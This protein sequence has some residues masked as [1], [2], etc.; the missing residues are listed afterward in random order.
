[1][2]QIE[3]SPEAQKVTPE[4]LERRKFIMNNPFIP[5]KAYFNTEVTKDNIRHFID[6]IG[7]SNPLFQDEE[8]AKKTKYGKIVAPGCFLYTNQWGTMSGGFAGV[9]AWYSGGDW[10]WYQPIYVGTRLK[11]V[12]VVRDSTVKKGRKAGGG[13]IYIDYGEVI[14]LNDDTNEILGKELFHTVWAERDAAGSSNK[15][16]SQSKTN[17][18][19]D[20]WLKI[21]ELYDTE[22]IRGAKHRYWEDVQS[23]DLLGPM[24]KGPLSVRD[25]VAWL[26]GGGSP[27]F[28]AHNLEFGFERRHPKALEYVKETGE[29]DVPELVHLLDQLARNIGVEYSYDYGG[30]LA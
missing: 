29:A 17:Y 14:Y 21:L 23:G 20:D 28:K 25:E 18:S 9:H 30:Q 7:D 2:P 16:R 19:R 10:E 15:E 3:S 24:L 5:P 4:A 12:T 6:G 8:Y 1:V 11:A 26:M 27:F 13:N 22:E